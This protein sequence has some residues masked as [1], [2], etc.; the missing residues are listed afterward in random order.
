M[1]L[2]V[3]TVP[4]GDILDT[5][6]I[7]D[8]ELAYAT[9]EARSLFENMFRRNP[10][11][12]AEKAYALLSGYTNGYVEV[13]EA[14]Q[15]AALN[16]FHLPGRHDQSTHGRRGK[17][18]LPSVPNPPSVPDVPVAPAP[19]R[20]RSTSPKAA[21]GKPKLTALVR[22]EKPSDEKTVAEAN[23]I[24]G[25]TFG[26][27]TATVTEATP[28]ELA[29]RNSLIVAGNIEDDQ[30]N[31]VGTFTR[32]VSLN[33]EDGKRTASHSSLNLAPKMRGQGFAEA[34]NSNAIDWYRANGIGEVHLFTAEVGGYAW[35][36]AGY[37]WGAPSGAEGV[38]KRVK[39]AAEPSSFGISVDGNAV[40]DDRLEAQRQLARD[41]LKRAESAKFGEVGY[42]TPYEISQL[43]RWPGAG[44][45]DMWIGKAIMLDS[46]WQGVRYL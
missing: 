13:E 14:D 18:A 20:A 31:R 17:R 39:A 24:W 21:P 29:G 44:K 25:G 37:D 30:G 3:K 41:L 33:K 19:K 10:E 9:G 5:V 35:A 1:S 8:G 36:R 16:E 23:K 22:T 32:S 45:D 6:T 34:F 4:E 46:S 11:M 40:P 43:G 28:V 38:L 2:L 12:T 26:G 27:L 15:T 42:P 7:D